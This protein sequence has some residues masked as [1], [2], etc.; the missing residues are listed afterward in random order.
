ME[1]VNELKPALLDAEVGDRAWGGSRQW[2]RRLLSFRSLF[3]W[4]QRLLPLAPA[5]PSSAA[6]RG[7]ALPSKARAKDLRPVL[8]LIDA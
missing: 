8:V 4:H 3:H 1:N 7:P 6:M 2:P 5:T